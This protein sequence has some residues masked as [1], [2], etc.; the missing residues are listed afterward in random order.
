MICLVAFF[1]SIWN[2]WQSDGS[3]PVRPDAPTGN[4][5]SAFTGTTSGTMHPSS[6][7]TAPSPGTSSKGATAGVPVGNPQSGSVTDP[8]AKP[9]R[10]ITLDRPLKSESIAFFGGN[11]SG[12]PVEPQIERRT[13]G[14]SIKL[15]V[16][17][18]VKE[19]QVQDGE[20]FA[21]IDIPGWSRLQ[22]IGKPAVPLKT[23]MLTI[24]RGVQP[25]VSLTVL[26]QV[27]VAPL[28]I[29]PTQ[30]PL[31]DVFP[32]PPRAPFQQDQALYA[33]NELFPS[34]NVV[35]Y[36]VGKLR[37]RR[38]LTIEVTPVQ[39]RAQSRIALVAEQMELSVTYVPDAQG[40]S[41]G[42]ADSG[43]DLPEGFA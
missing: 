5:S 37:N 4:Q 2:P 24:P 7:S 40:V 38:I 9:L 20:V 6:G 26:A 1:G 14:Y 19:P 28:S 29:W 31:P 23:I 42:G 32:E 18:F 10:I 41:G 30:P 34:N 39:V 17:G 21:R 43:E 3:A 13:N 16:P 22:E 36:S 35:G 11:L 33:S 8:D 12:L 25:K 27:Q 15:H